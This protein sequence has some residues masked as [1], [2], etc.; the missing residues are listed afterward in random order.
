MV[1]DDPQKTY[2][3]LVLDMARSHDDDD[4]RAVDGFASEAAAR[5]YAEARTRASVEELRGDG[6]SADAIRRLWYLYGEDCLV[7]GG[8]YRGSDA[9][10][11]YIATPADPN[12][13]DWPALTPRVKRFHATLLVANP[14]NVTVWAG[15]FLYR[16]LEPS[17]ATLMRIF[18]DQALA[19]FER[20]GHPA[21]VLADLHLANLFE[22]LDPPAPP[23]GLPLRR[24]RVD[25]DFV[26]HDIKFGAHA[27]G[28]FLW[29]EQPGGDALQ[30][31]ARVL[32][33]DSLALRGDGP[34]WVDYSEAHTLRVEATDS[35]PDYPLRPSETPLPP[36]G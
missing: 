36:Q 22:L 13:L 32:M 24:W 27:G 18:R 7:V 9:L 11:G 12:T 26:C 15:G 6:N 3:V 35:E 20:K 8:A 2:S 1:T 31:M 34:D 17:G 28:V 4:N 14:D 19:A 10:D 16:Y 21:A 25:V 30:S 29:P 23:P 33:G 5:A